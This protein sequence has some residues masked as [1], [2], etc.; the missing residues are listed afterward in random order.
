MDADER[1]PELLRKPLAVT[2]IG[3]ENFAEYLQ[4]QDVPLVHVS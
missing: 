3:G 4:V 1:A 2:N